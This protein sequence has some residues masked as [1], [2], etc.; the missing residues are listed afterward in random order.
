MRTVQRLSI[1]LV[2]GLALPLQASASGGPQMTLGE[3]LSESKAMVHGVVVDQFSQWEESNG[4]KII[5]TYSTL[6]V[7][8][9]QFGKLGRMQNVVVRTVGGSVDGYNQVLIDEASFTPGEEVIVFLGLEDG[10]L[11]PS[12]VGFHQGKYTVSRN[13]SGRIL[14]LRQDAGAQVDRKEVEKTPLI[15]LSRFVEEVRRARRGSLERDTSDVHPLV[16][17]K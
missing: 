12:V 10:W 13:A 6:R 11:H 5:F 9:G 8:N 3:V 15:P 2:L 1:A 4:N 14:G 16:R 7:E 17:I